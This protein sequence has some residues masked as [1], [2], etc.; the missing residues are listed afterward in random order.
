MLKVND[1]MIKNNKETNKINKI[2]CFEKMDEEG[3][4]GCL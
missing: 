2:E 4:R 3:K 1:E